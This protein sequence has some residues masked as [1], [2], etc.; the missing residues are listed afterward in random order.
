MVNGKYAV[1]ASKKNAYQARLHVCRSQPALEA[2]RIAHS[3]L[4]PDTL[5]NFTERQWSLFIW[6]CRARIAKSGASHGT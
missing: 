5:T 6:R 1:R 2:L 3:E 4:T